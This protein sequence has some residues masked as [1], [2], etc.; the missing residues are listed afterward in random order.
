[1]KGTKY[2]YQIIIAFLFFFPTVVWAHPH[3]FIKSSTTFVWNEDGTLRGAYMEWAFDR[4]FSTDIIKWLDNN[5]DG[6][7]NEKENTAV[8]NNAFI[9]LK[10][11][12]YYIFIRQGSVR[13]NPQK[14]RE[15][16]ATQ[17]DGIMKYRFFIDLSMYK[18]KDLY[19]AVYDYTYFCDIEYVSGGIQ[20]SCPETVHPSF[21]IIENKQYPVYYDPLSPPT[22]TSVHYKWAPGLQTYYPREIELKW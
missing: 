1:M 21:K 16:K 13:T 18:G 12:Y 10:N 15:F 14:V 17:S 3:V 9:N 19:I 20:F 5:H 11:Y 22:D 2:K 4:F 8:Y 6:I 7:F